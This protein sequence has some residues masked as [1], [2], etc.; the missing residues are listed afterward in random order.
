MYV[1]AALLCPSIGQL[2]TEQ[3]PTNA[4]QSSWVFL[5]DVFNLFPIACI[6]GKWL[7]FEGD[8]IMLFLNL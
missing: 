6:G 8:S 5:L 3:P 1:F 4:T 2:Y 7:L